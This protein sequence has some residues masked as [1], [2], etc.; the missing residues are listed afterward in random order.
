MCTVD[1]VLSAYDDF[2]VHQ[3]S[4]PIARTASSDINHYD[5]YF[6]NGYSRRQDGG[7]ALYFAVAMGLYPNRHVADASFSVIL[8]GA[9]QISVHA[10]RR[11][12]EDRREANQVGPIEVEVVEPL[13]TLRIKVDAPNEGLRAELTFRARSAALEEPHFFHQSGQRVVLDYT[14]L[15][16]FGRWEGWIE[17]GGR[18]LQCSPAE[19][20]GS[21]DRSWGVRPVGERAPTGA[22][23]GAPQFYW[24]WAPVNFGDFATHFDVNELSD[25]RRWH[26]VG[27]VVPDAGAAIPADGVDYRIGWR[28]GT[29]HA[30]S[31]SVDLHLAA[32]GT[33][34]VELTPR[35]EFQMAGL[36]YGHPEWGHGVWKGELA[37]AGE[38]WGLPVDDPCA[39]H[40]VHVQTL[41]DAR[42]EGPRGVHEGI[43]ILE[44]FVVGE[45][46]PTG[47]TGLFDPA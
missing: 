38:R 42:A 11:A 4:H 24:L 37:V 1:G 6:F 9:E 47:L 30:A 39:P 40:H 22:P 31:F 18:R 45:H 44:T 2:P 5:R 20:W 25:G 27:F 29:R 36:G 8:E 28:P 46:A 10:S 17:I 3:T 26:E 7:E 41:C 43:G 23:V 35:Y 12:P 14:R 19:T 33:T 15:T 13:R 16:Q 34:H 21:R 32:E